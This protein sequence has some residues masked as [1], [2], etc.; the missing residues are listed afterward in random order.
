MK[1]SSALRAAIR[2]AD[3]L[4]TDGLFQRPERVADL[5]GEV[6]AFRELAEVLA[7]DPHTAVRRFLA[8]SMRLCNAGTAGLSILRPDGAGKPAFHWDA[9]GGALAGL[10]GGSISRDFS[11]SG[12]CL[13][14][15]TTILVSRPERVFTSLQAAEPP[16]AEAL[17]VPL[18]DTARRELGTLWIAHHDETA[19]FCVNDVRVLE[20]LAIQLVL[21]L[22]LLALLESY[23]TVQ[24]AGAHDLAEERS[25]RVHAEAAENGIRQNLAF[26]DAA[27]KDAH[28]RVKNTLQLVTS[29]LSM[30]A[31]ATVSVEARLALLECQGRL[32]LLA[33]V[34]ELLYQSADSGEEVVM[35][36]LL[37]AIGDALRGSFAEE[38]NRISLTVTSERI[39]L[40]PDDAIPIALLA[41][42]A[43]TNAYKHAFCDGSSGQICV[44]LS[45]A[46]ENAMLLEIKDDGM[47][48][49]AGKIG[50]GLKL[51]HI[52]AAQ[53]QGTLI[54][55][56]PVD[57]RGH[58]TTVALR[59]PGG[60]AAE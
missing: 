16:I 24:Q 23:E 21:A 8:I 22:K 51:M 12:L 58:G 45:S 47:G 43:I 19:R 27:I 9:I 13:D 17:I 5:Q 15:G 56:K 7:R 20:Q 57:P 35:P 39:T 29:L 60:T 59:I 41:N 38:S 40:S 1:T 26:K 55:A 54:L 48:M 42:E 49:R 4:S 3:V 37:L 36:T 50:M 11:P 53:L 25:R 10:E 14:T 18:Y 6:A 2:P 52:F 32:S 44:E 28:H 31:R 34:H 46:A 30:Q 33:T